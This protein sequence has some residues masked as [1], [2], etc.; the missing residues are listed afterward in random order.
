MRKTIDIEEKY[1]IGSAKVR[2]NLKAYGLGENVEAC[3]LHREL[4]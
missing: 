4:I 2:F 3:P 1:E